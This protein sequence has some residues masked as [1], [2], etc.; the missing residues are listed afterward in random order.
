LGFSFIFVLQRHGP[1]P[2]PGLNTKQNKPK[3]MNLLLKHSRLNLVN[4]VIRHL[5]GFIFLKGLQQPVIKRCPWA[6]SK[7]GDR[8]TLRNFISQPDK[9]GLVISQNILHKRQHAW[10]KTPFDPK[11]LFISSNFFSTNFK[12]LN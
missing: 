4:F 3:H 7:T 1:N 12:I 11:N 6:L 10:L 8:L 9:P 5:T 2:C